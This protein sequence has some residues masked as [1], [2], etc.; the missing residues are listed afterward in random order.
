MYFL[1]GLCVEKENAFPL[2]AKRF[3]QST[4]GKCP[5]GFSS[6]ENL[7]VFAGENFR[8]PTR[9]KQSGL[10]EP[11]QQAAAIF[12]LRCELCEGNKRLRCHMLLP[13]MD[14][15]EL[16]A[17]ITVATYHWIVPLRTVNLHY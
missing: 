17:S 1:S 16:Q 8:L 5:P 3:L 4:K 2:K 14:M 9:E 7:R 13:K 12:L 15:I 11:A 6:A 10:Y